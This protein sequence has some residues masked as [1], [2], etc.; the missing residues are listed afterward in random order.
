ME[1]PMRRNAVHRSIILACGFFGCLWLTGAAMA[2]KPKAPLIKL[3]VSFGSAMENTPVL[4]GGRALLV[5]NFRDDSKKKSGDCMKDMY[6]Y[7]RDLATGEEVGPH[8]GAGHSFVSAFVR[9]REIHVFATQADNKD[10]FHDVYHFSSTDLKTWK[11]E[12]ALQRAPG[13]HLFNTSV[14][15]D[16]RGYLMAYES[17]KPIAF[18]FRFARS[19]DLSKWEKIPGLTFTGETIEYS[20]CPVIR[21][22]APYYYVIYLHAAIPGHNGWVPFMARSRDLAVWQLSPANPILEASAGEG[23]NNSDIDLFEWEG[24]TYLFY[25]TG[26]QQTWGNVREAM[27]LGPMKTFFEACFPA[28]SKMIEVSAKTK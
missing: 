15:R 24:N 11:R 7:I 22:F 8:F 12:L 19:K 10:W 1:N 23:C 16:D 28:G 17:D 14:C 3:P 18:C 9:G 4:Y 26:D 13:E 5:L 20:A 2:Q 27:F 25:A 6:L 21:Y